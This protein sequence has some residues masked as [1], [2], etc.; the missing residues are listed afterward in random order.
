MKE[1]IIEG[2]F[3]R[4]GGIPGGA[5]WEAEW[6]EFEELHLDRPPRGRQ[7]LVNRI[8]HQRN[9]HGGQGFDGLTGYYRGTYYDKGVARI[10]KRE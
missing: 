6:V 3:D 4:S 9:L 1:K 5:P 2:Q 10:S 8:N 7:R